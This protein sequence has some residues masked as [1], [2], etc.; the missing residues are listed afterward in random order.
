VRPGATRRW[1]GIVV[2]LVAVA[3][4]AYWAARQEPPRIPTDPEHLFYLAAAVGLYG[5][6]TLLRGWRWHQILQRLGAGHRTADAYGLVTV[7]YMGNTVLPARGGEVLRTVLLAGRSTTGKREVVG[8]I[9][10]ERALDAVSLAVLFAALTWA[11]IAGSPLGERPA[12]LAVGVL[13]LL[14]V[15]IWAYL[16]ARRRGRLD[17]IA[18]RLRPFVLASRPLLGRAGVTLLLVTIVVWMLEGTIFFLVGRS[19]ALET[20]IMEGLFLVVLSAVAALI[21]AGPGYIGTFDASLVFGLH[22][23][24]VTGGQAVGFVLLVRFV[25]FV[26]ITLVGL[27]VLVMRYGRDRTS[28]AVS[29]ATP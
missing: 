29:A 20:S 17:G 2:S 19:L 13:A 1:G 16:R 5:V 25:L 9:I 26:P 18:R 23:I 6:A 22:A 28:G 4:V 14:G 10:S 21:P 27:V 24:G 11:G 15:S 12:L 7:G 3:S 8:S